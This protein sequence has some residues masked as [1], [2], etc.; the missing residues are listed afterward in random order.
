[1]G[2]KIER[3][4]FLALMGLSGAAVALNCGEGPNYDETWKPWVEPV[5]GTIPYEPNYYAT[6][7]A[8]SDGAGLWVKVLGGRASKI[9]GNP[10]HPVNRGT[11]TAR[12][13]SVI[14]S[15]YGPDRLREPVARQGGKATEITW[16]DARALLAQ[17]L[18]EAKGG[19]V[20]A[21]T[22]LTTGAVNDIWTRFVAAMGSGKL[23]HYEPFSQSDLLLAGEKA[24]G[25]A[26]VPMFSLKGADC[27]VSLGAQFLETW[28]DVTANSRHYGE[29]KTLHDGHRG[30][31]VQIEPKVTGTGANADNHLTARP[32]SETHIA[33]ALLKQVAAQSHHLNA[34][35]QARVSALTADASFE[36]AAAMAGIKPDALKSVADALLGASAALVLP[37]E[38]L[39]LGKAA[40][41]HHVA[42]LL[43][44]KAVGA[45]G[46]RVN[47]AAA[48]PITRVPD[49]G[50]VA[51]FV[52]DLNGGGVDLLI[53]SGSNPVF[54]LPPGLKFADALAKAKFSIYLG[55]SRNETSALCDLVMPVNHPLEA[56]GEINTYAGLDMLQQPVMTPR[57]RDLKQAED[58]LIESLATMA[59][60]AVGQSNFR[61][62][63]KAG[64]LARFSAEAGGDQE[65]FWR[66]SLKRGG[67][68]SLAE[69]GPDLPVSGN[70]GGDYFATLSDPPAHAPALVLLP[71]PR[72]GDGSTANRGWMQELPDLMTGVTW[73]S[74]LEMSAATAAGIGS[75]TGNGTMVTVAANG[76]RL[77]I[78]AF[79]TD[80]IGDQV[81]CLATGQG[82]TG[83]HE[84]FNRGSNAFEFLGS[85]TNDG[86]LFS[87]G[88]L[89]VS[90][91][92]SA[93]P[94]RR[95]ATFHLPGKGDRIN[96]PLAMLEEGDHH[97]DRDLYQTVALGAV[98][99]GG[100]HGGHGPEPDKDLTF[101]LHREQEKD[102]YPDRSEDKLYKN[103]D[104]TFYDPYKWEMSLDLNKCN[105]C[106]SCV[107][108]CYAENNLPVVGRDQVIKGREM[109]WIRINRY[110]SFTP[111]DGHQ[112]VSVGFLPLMCQ[113][114]GNAPCESVCPSLATYHNKEGLNAMV[115]NRCVGTRYCSNNC[116]YKVRRFNWFSWEKRSTWKEQEDFHWY[117]NPE[118]SV[119]QAGVMEKCTFCSHRIRTAKD[120]ARDQG[121]LVADGEVKTACQQACPA[122]AINFGNFSDK[123]SKVHAIAHDALAYR[124][125]DNHL[126]TKPGVSYLKRVLLDGGSEASHG[127]EADHG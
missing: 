102:F 111:K 66:D 116:S 106:G 59:V 52:N 117:M 38:S 89:A 107:T 78:P 83:L 88:P 121:R 123:Q 104:E 110:L 80:T 42:V 124:A 17:K 1:M 61:D 36:K 97:Y 58:V 71:S 74:W 82:H 10:E 79:I 6:T 95:M 60:G 98:G 90:L 68:F 32:G 76:R 56:W 48:R 94:R 86:G 5:A 34:E 25:R 44:N 3:R 15:L 103:R 109:A 57:W 47:Y 101:P 13:Q 91:S 20:C 27:V 113:Q 45:I 81:V 99:A 93:S 114:C 70:L 92:R 14:Q 63:L 23:V 65:K 19:N 49:H 120:A 100:G 55:D 4:D 115:Y 46:P 87:A 118:V 2:N 122:N 8:E 12:Q 30:R 21:L 62:F 7:T 73:D 24:F 26:E 39:V 16:R 85:D 51:A 127:H 105:G 108:A 119:R 112:Q 37:A 33:L 53:I 67:H 84:L 11:L 28:G 29:M 77:D 96:T 50:T 69:S 75:G 64:W 126:H 18:A 43:L 22:G 35:E 72:F 54:S 125:L 40:V 41:A 9:E 31:H